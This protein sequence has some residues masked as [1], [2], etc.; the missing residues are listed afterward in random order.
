[1]ITCNVVCSFVSVSMLVSLFSGYYC[2]ALT[3]CVGVCKW[4]PVSG[5]YILLN[6]FFF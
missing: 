6:V 2:S 3:F 1:M 4:R 5:G